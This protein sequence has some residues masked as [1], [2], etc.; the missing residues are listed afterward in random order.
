MII[1]CLLSSLFLLPSV[2]A[3]QPVLT[4]NDA[5]DP[6]FSTPARD[7]FL[8][9]VVGEAFRRAGVT[10]KLVKLPPERGL[11]NANEG[12]EDGELSRIG[13]L[14]KHYPNLV[15]VP[16][17][18]YD[19]EFVVFTLKKK[20]SRVSWTALEPLS[21]GH[22]KGWKIFEQNLTPKTSVTLADT[23][24]QLFELLK[25]ERIDAALYGGWMGQVLI[26]QM[27]IKGARANKPPLATRE[28]FIYLH[29][30]HADLAPRLAAELRAMKR[31]GSY[32]KA[33]DK[34]LGP[35]REATAL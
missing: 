9:I 10:L 22:I 7:G 26:R 20:L 30:R 29:K 4:L 28:M 1:G 27:D 24:A 3:A 11:I 2:Q 32:Q 21:V 25:R 16:E 8:D 34:T 17:K 13:G 14:E 23:P 12:I 18:T 33:Y 6:P 31:D 35:Y 15:R 5:N 19:L